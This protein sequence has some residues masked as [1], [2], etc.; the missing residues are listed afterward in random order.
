M[1]APPRPLTTD[2]V[3]NLLLGCGLLGGGGG[4][5]E[6]YARYLLAEMG[7][8]GG[9][10]RLTRLEQ[11]TDE[12][13]VFRPFFLGAR[14]DFD[15]IQAFLEQHEEALS[16]Y[17]LSIEHADETLRRHVGGAPAAYLPAEI[18]PANTM[19]ALHLAALADGVAT[20]AD[21]AGRAVPELSLDL[22]ATRSCPVAPFALATEFGERLICQEIVDAARMEQI[23]RQLARCSGGIVA[24]VQALRVGDVRDAVIS[25]S[26]SRA[27]RLGQCV[28]D[29]VASGEPPLERLFTSG[30]ATPLFHGRIARSRQMNDEAFIVGEHQIDG[31]GD[32]PESCSIWYKNE[33][34]VMW[35][36]GHPFATCPDVI[37]VVDAQTG[38]PLFNDQNDHLRGREVVVVGIP[39]DPVW[40]SERRSRLTPRYFG[41]PFDA[42]PVGG[43]PAT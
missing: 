35:V 39:A 13:V 34:L 22:P 7:S 29:A 28:R 25:G 24:V 14:F 6:R 31:L 17:R 18:G 1:T 5:G 11:L 9:P 40:R 43:G 41:Y 42:I 20:D 32:G 38:E 26:L 30:L 10:L 12:A 37:A 16:S 36:N 15:Q 19:V 23:G 2:D 21:C 3:E 4:G 33:N 8:R 27:I